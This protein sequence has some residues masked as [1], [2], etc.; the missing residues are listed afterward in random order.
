MS[1]MRRKDKKVGE[2]VISPVS[3]DVVNNLAWFETMSSMLF[4]YMAMLKDSLAINCN[5]LISIFSSRSRTIL[6]SLGN[7]GRAISFE[8]L[9]VDTTIPKTFMNVVASFNQASSFLLVA[10]TNLLS[11]IVTKKSSAMHTAKTFTM[12][13]VITIFYGANSHG[14]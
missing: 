3:I 5:K 10:M 12:V 7:I 6:C 14:M 13:F 8:T 1:R 9:I 4:Y 2:F 11:I